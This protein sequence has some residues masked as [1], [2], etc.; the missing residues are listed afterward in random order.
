MDTP[1]RILERRRSVR[2]SEPL[3]FKIGLEGYD[4][5][6]I[7]INLSSHGTMCV[8]DRDIPMMSQVNVGL[9]LPSG[10]KPHNRRLL[11]MKGVVVRKHKDPRTG[12]FLIAIYFSDIKPDD[13]KRLESFIGK[14]LKST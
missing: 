8:I 2:I 5:H 4:I 11:R 9:E 3:L 14:Y 1:K 12:R 10:K 13:Q 6:A 7:T